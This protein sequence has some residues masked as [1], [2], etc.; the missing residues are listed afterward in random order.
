MNKGIVIAGATGEVGRRLAENLIARNLNTPIYALVRGHSALLPEGITQILVDF[1]QLKNTQLPG[2]ISMGYCCLGTTIKQAGSQQA[3]KQVD[4][5]YA[6]NFAHWVQS[7]GATQFACISSVGANRRSKNFYL[8]VKGQLEHDLAQM[9]WAHLWLLRP[10]LLL[11]PRQAFRL[12]EYLGAI[13]SQ[14]I[15]PFLIGPLKKYKPIHMLKVAETLAQL[16]V[17]ESD[18]TG[19]KV[20]EGSALFKD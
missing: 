9:N 7:K 18:K 20:L 4:H 13:L 19:C 6:L 8:A 11:G 2:P 10:S 16:A 1:N 17:Q 14:F 5:D 15:S 12:G 3:F